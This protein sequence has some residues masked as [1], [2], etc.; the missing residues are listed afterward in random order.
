MSYQPCEKELKQIKSFERA[1]AK[2]EKA[3]IELKKIQNEVAQFMGHKDYNSLIEIS[4]TSKSIWDQFKAVILNH[5][6]K[7]GSYYDHL[8]TII[9]SNRILEKNKYVYWHYQEQKA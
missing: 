3:L 6:Y 9:K 7:W 8:N 5:S 2:K 4:L 1:K